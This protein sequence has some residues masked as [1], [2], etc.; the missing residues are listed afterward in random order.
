MMPGTKSRISI[1]CLVLMA[2]WCAGCMSTTPEKFSRQVK[3]WVPLGTPAAEAQ[4]IMEHH[5]FE[6]RLLTKDH[7]F[8]KY[9]VDYLDCDQE[10]VR[11]HDWH[12]QF[13]LEDDKVSRY[14]SMGIDDHTW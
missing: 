2:G 8:N 1:L 4:H 9:G 7:P 14:G 10:Q 12:V 13:F 6:C 5:G 11:L 3:E